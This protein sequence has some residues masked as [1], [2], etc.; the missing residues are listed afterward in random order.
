MELVNYQAMRKRERS[1]LDM[2]NAMI[3]R[4]GNSYDNRQLTNPVNLLA[5]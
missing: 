4:R 2:R 1:V 5:E 3:M